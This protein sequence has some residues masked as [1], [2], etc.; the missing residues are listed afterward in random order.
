MTHDRRNG[1]SAKFCSL[2]LVL[3]ALALTATAAE[4]GPLQ[5]G[6]A[7]VDITPPDLAGFTNQWGTRFEGVHDKIYVRA[8]AIDN[9]RTMAAIVSADLV[10]FG[11][12]TAI[13][14]RIEKETGIP[15]DH[16]FISATHDHNA[17][18][19]GKVSPGATARSGTAVTDAYTN[20]V[21]ERILDAVRQAKSQ[22][23]RA[24]VGAGAGSADVNTNRDEFTAQGWKLGVNPDRPSDKTVWVLRFDTP[25]GEPIAFFINYAVHPVVMGPENKFLTADLAGATSRYVEQHYNDKVVALWMSG[26]AGDQNPKFITWDTTFT[27]KTIRPGFSL[28]DSQSQ[29]LAE[30]VLR[31]AGLIEHKASD[32]RL[33]AAQRILACP[34]RMNPSRPAQVSGP[35]AKQV[36][37][38][39]GLLMIDR[40]AL[41]A[42]SAEVVANIYLRLRRESP[43]TSTILVTLANDRIGELIDDVAYETPYFETGAT[44]VEKNCAESG[45]V[46]GILEMMREFGGKQ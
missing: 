30:E 13:R 27:N 43:Y 10:E 4:R 12:T 18:R 28:L 29:I 34:A 9:S 40:I 8:L 33:T 6:S 17:P 14:Q 26:A 39:L 35:P 2:L 1:F 19:V 38:R 20:Y 44:P 23:Q 37:I 31:T 25:D 5:I 36:E 16:I 7:R 11:D 41:A 32:V 22:M 15:A 3:M 21:Y 42:V 24:V 45:I 46:N